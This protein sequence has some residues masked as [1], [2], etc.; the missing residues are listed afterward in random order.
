MKARGFALLIVLTAGP[1]ALLA[2]NLT[3]GGTYVQ[4]WQGFGTSP[5]TAT[6]TSLTPNQGM[7]IFCLDFNDEIAPPTAWTATIFTLSK[8]IVDGTGAY[9]GQFAA[10]YGGAYN[11]LVTAAFNNPSDP[12]AVGETKAPQVSGQAPG[13][14]PPYAF[15][16]DTS[17]HVSVSLA[18]T[19][20]TSDPAYTRYLEAAWLFE[21]IQS[22]PSGNYNNTE[23]IDQVAAWDLFVNGAN[24][25]ALTADI[26]GT[27]GTFAFTNYLGLAPHQTYLTTGTVTAQTT[28]GLN[29]EQAVDV[30]LAAAQTA[31]VNDSWG[32]TSHDYGTWSLVTATPAYVVQ[33]GLPVQEFLS[34]NAVPDSGPVP[35]PKAIFLLATVAAIVAW[36][37]R[38]RRRTA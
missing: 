19:N 28:S 9:A 31:V 23:L 1:G 15:N 25:P 14:V 33:Y 38:R 30:A 11:N 2:D 12:K 16:S 37:Y 27:G 5:Y 7:Q 10:Q 18:A 6:D 24:L 35:E 3:W 32:P 17:G 29:F 26:T 34:P 8:S 22:A 21:N 4:A 20:A 36:A 13:V